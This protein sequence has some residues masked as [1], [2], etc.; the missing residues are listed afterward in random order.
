MRRWMAVATAA[1]AAGLCIASIASA[2]AHSPAAT[3]RTATWY[4]S[5][6]W[7]KS[8]LRKYGVQFDDGRTF[9]VQQVYCLGVGGLQTCS[10]S[11]DHSFRTY[12]SFTAYVRS[13]DGTVR[14]FTLRPTGKHAFRGS[15]VRAYR[16]MALDAFIA[17]T[18]P[19]VAKAARVE[20]AKGCGAP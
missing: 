19:F 5:P 15:N 6:S 18:L 11:S 7:C 17:F 4:W 20:Q 2:S 8:T 1:L 16:K 12:R 3:S 10:W 14:V 13:Y 9:E